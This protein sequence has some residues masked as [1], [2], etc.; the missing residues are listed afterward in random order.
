[1]KT[2]WTKGLE[3]DAKAEMKLHYNGSV[4]LRKRLGV[5]LNEKVDAKNRE[6]MKDDAY[7]NPS[8]AYLMA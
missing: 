4:Q 1:M 8:W 7:D 2:A 3:T 5:L 6:M